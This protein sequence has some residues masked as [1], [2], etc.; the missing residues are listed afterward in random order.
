[1]R[2]RPEVQEK[3]ERRI[4]SV[5]VKIINPPRPG[6]RQ[7]PARGCVHT[8]QRIWQQSP[9]ALRTAMLIWGLRQSPLAGGT[10][11]S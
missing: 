5:E 8:M 6:V 11:R 3:L 10:S 2:D 9:V 7:L 4:R 1:V